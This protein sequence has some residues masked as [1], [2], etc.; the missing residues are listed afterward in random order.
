[1]GQGIDPRVSEEM[2]Y[3]PVVASD[4]G[5]SPDPRINEGCPNVFWRR[6]LEATPKDWEAERAVRS[7]ESMVRTLMVDLEERC[8]ETFPVEDECFA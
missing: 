6:P 4:F 7:I 8:G 1:M 2:P 3:R 5:F